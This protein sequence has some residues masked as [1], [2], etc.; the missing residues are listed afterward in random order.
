[1][2]FKEAFQQKDKYYQHLILA[3]Q[4]SII[5]VFP[6]KNPN[7][8]ESIYSLENTKL[9]KIK[10]LILQCC[11]VLEQVHWHWYQT[12][13]FIGLGFQKL[14]TKKSKPTRL[15]SPKLT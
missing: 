1:M 10:C 8:T 12:Q 5:I 4:L 14:H 2:L 7:S 3:S 11:Q 15:Y 9:N 6:D 13:L